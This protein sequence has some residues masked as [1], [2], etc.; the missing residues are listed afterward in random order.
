MVEISSPPPN[1][2][3]LAASV[4]KVKEQSPALLS[5]KKTAKGSTLRLSQEGKKTG[6]Q[7]FETLKTQDT[8]QV[9]ESVAVL[10]SE[11]TANVANLR[12]TIRQELAAEW[13]SARMKQSE[14]RE[15]F[16]NTLAKRLTE[17]V[18]YQQA[19]LIRKLLS[20]VTLQIRHEEQRLLR[21]NILNAG[22]TDS[23]LEA[24][25]A[26]LQADGKDI[27]NRALLR[28]AYIQSRIKQ[29]RQEGEAFSVVTTEPSQQKEGPETQQHYERI[30][31]RTGLPTER[32]RR[33]G[34]DEQGTR[35][36]AESDQRHE[37]VYRRT[38]LLIKRASER[39]DARR[40]QRISTH[41]LVILDAQ[42]RL[43]SL[44]NVFVLGKTQVA[45]AGLGVA[46]LAVSV[47]PARELSQVPIQIPIVQVGNMPSLPELQFSF[48]GKNKLANPVESIVQQQGEKMPPKPVAGDF[49]QPTP[50]ESAPSV[51]NSSTNNTVVE[52]KPFFE[53]TQKKPPLLAKFRTKAPDIFVPGTRQK[54]S[55]DVPAQIEVKGFGHGYTLSAQINNATYEIPIDQ[56]DVSNA[57]VLVSQE[58]ARSNFVGIRV[59]SPE[60]VENAAQLGAKSVRINGEGYNLSN[61]T[62][63]SESEVENVK[64][65]I[66]KAKE[67]NL[68]MLYV[69]HPTQLLSRE[70][71]QNQLK[72][73]Y[74]EVGDYPKFT[75][76]LGNEFNS[77]YFWKDGNLDTFSEFV[78]VAT[79]TVWKM[80]PDAKMAL[81]ALDDTWQLEKLLLKLKKNNVSV[82]KFNS[83]AL[84]VYGGEKAMDNVVQE[85][86]RALK[87]QNLSVP[88]VVSEY[89]STS[90]GVVNGSVLA[91]MTDRAQQLG[92]KEVFIHE[93]DGGEGLELFADYNQPKSSALIMKKWILDHR[94]TPLAS[95][96]KVQT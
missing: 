3:D 41:K 31:A 95:Q 93:A 75:L 86:S 68:E 74:N 80:H 42:R 71:I 61:P 36:S 94:T 19:Q 48:P 67:N 16:K 20:S 7:L 29:L 69:Y 43:G 58:K 53:E 21:E 45:L 84:H 8:Q 70:E 81:G 34:V 11:I 10:R 62:K 76:E 56:L 2:P 82:G 52:P 44:R 30:Y 12:K 6:K 55:M 83:V 92:L 40:V 64:K 87:G 96:V 18:S 72:A 90:V 60:G 47:M 89:S 50:L 14:N 26:K 4:A 9:R 39:A 54:V 17:D 33:R 79:D 85:A 78:K 63:S 24:Y 32:A 91:R 25:R 46:A 5:Q 38:G 35:G 77:P 51:K 73:I 23:D 37:R 13:K 57:N 15:E 49:T 66:K 59:N 65:T 88:L 28:N 27:A 22:I 1:K